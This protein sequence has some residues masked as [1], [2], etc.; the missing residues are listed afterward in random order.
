MDVDLPDGALCRSAAAVWEIGQALHLKAT[1]VCHRWSVREEI[2]LPKS[3]G[4]SRALFGTNRTRR[5]T[6]AKKFC[7]RGGCLPRLR[8]GVRSIITIGWPGHP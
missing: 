5:E 3:R 4:H 1:P 8:R 7:A 2:F 6:K